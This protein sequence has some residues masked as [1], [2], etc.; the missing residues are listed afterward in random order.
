LRDFARGAEVEPGI[1]LGFGCIEADAI[2]DRLRA[3][4][5]ALARGRTTG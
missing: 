2:R 1:T 4:G 3:L 5:R